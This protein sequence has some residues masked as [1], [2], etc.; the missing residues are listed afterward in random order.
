MA[1][2]TIKLSDI[3]ANP[4]GGITQGSMPRPNTTNPN[5]SLYN[6]DGGSGNSIRPTSDLSNGGGNGGYVPP[7]PKT[8]EI[9]PSAVYMDEIEAAAHDK[10]YK[11]LL[12]A[13]IA[14]YQLKMNTQK[15][16][17]NGLAAQG[18]GN[19]GYGTSAHV[20]VENTAANLYAQNLENFN[21]AESEEHTAAIGRQ[22]AASTESDNQLVTFLQYSD[23]SSE[24]IAGY[25]DKY[26]YVQGDDGN[27]Y[28]KGDDGKADM[29]KPASN[30]VQSA[31]QS[32]TENAAANGSA[33]YSANSDPNV[34]SGAQNALQNWGSKYSGI[35]TNGYA[36]VSDLRQ[37]V[38]G[39][40]DNSTTDKLQNIVTNELNYLE[41]RIN[42]GTIADGTLF[43]LQRGNGFGEAYLVLYLGGKLYIVSDDDREQGEYQVSSR[44]NAYQGPKEE[45]KGK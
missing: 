24:S 35:N 18:L 6:D 39:N 11:A 10:N 12:D 40:R 2:K 33:D 27:W 20:G 7:A 21:Q 4:V 15:Y 8:P 43:K 41:A 31:I 23:G 32:A 16:L 1:Q 19:Q 13:D 3:Y 45:I 37:A 36:S 26:G 5:V 34:V 9:D 30:Y 29:S 25:M 42:T 14:A 22:E 28:K 44:Y 17:E 38:V